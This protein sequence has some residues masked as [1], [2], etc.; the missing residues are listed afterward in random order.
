MSDNPHR[1]QTKYW[2]LFTALLLLAAALILPPLINMNRYQRRIAD[3][4]GNSLGRRVHL[5]SVTLR[6][7]PRPGL[8]LTDFLVEEDPTFGTEP[9]LRA[10]SVD[11]YIRL[12]SLWRGRLEIG[13]ISFDQPS[14]NLVRDNQ[15]R[16]NIGTV[17]L[18]ASHIPNAPT[19]QRRASSAP[20][21]PYIEASNARVNFKIV[22]EK[23]PYS[24]LNADFAMWLANP[25]EWRI[26]LEAQPVRTDLDLGLSD[27]GLL[28]VEGS[29]HR[30]SALGEMPIDLEAEWSNAPLGQIARLL[31]GQDT[32]WRGSL[33]VTGDI[34]GDVFNPQFKTRIRI[35]GIHRQEFTPLEAFNVD[36][37]CQGEYRHDARALENLTCL[38]PIDGGH[39]LLTGA[40][41]DLEHPKPAFNL[42][43]QNLPA[44]FGLSALRLVRNGFASSTQVSG[45][46]QGSLAYTQSPA[47]NLTGE[48][49]VSGLTLRTPGMEPPLALP[50]LH[51][52]SPATLPPHRRSATLRS[53]LASAPLALHLANASI[54]L[55]EDVPLTISGDFNR[56]GFSLYLNGG[57]SLERLPPITANIGLMYSAVSGLA[58]HGSATL[59]L[60][61]RGPWLSPT[62]TPGN[63]VPTATTEGSLSLKNASYQASFLPESVEIVSAQAALT[64][65]QIIWNPVSIVFHKIPATLSI[66]VPI[67]CSTPACVRE[68]SLS[69]PQ[70]DAA[71]LQS[72][73]M[74]AGEHGEFLQQILARLDRNK[75]E[76]PALNGTVR[77]A[78][79]SVGQLPLHDASASLHIEGRQIQFTSMEAHT[80]NGILQATGTMDATGSTP[81]YSFDAQLFHA[82]TAGLAALWRELPLSG[83]VSAT[84]HLEL[85]GYSTDDLAQ[86]AQGT[87]HWDWTQGGTT[88]VP[89][90]LTHFDRWSADGAIKNKQLTLGQSEIIRGPARQNVTGTISFDRKPNLTVADHE[91]PAHVA[92]AAQHTP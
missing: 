85:S 22:N 39:L 68:F 72:A 17:L 84:T 10:A 74:G 18:Q 45:T 80:L 3:S 34:K 91:E 26:R 43:I 56:Q 50:P 36:A 13:R 65:T 5:S 92:K 77:T 37:T 64:P 4:I 6:L 20:R 87:F 55:G 54:Q 88:L 46:V 32:G 24:F 2:I 7:L 90:A 82:N 29:L 23:K 75:V 40:I 28:R 31:L 73:V 14:L 9:T 69:T 11:A 61:I 78:S 41:P 62:S 30:A 57:A 66:T 21:F 48:A 49:I 12:T 33:D 15:G 8:E 71:A 76:W 51:I 60:A 70:L 19:A 1:S 35:A 89:A 42:Q 58:P 59:D 27:T 67:P 52:A 63:P 47:E 25:D 83:I 44:A 79:F 38:W 86:S 81:R 53:S 16:W